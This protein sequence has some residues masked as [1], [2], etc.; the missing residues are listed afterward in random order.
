[1]TIFIILLNYAYG[2]TAASTKFKAFYNILDPA[3]VEPSISST[4]ASEDDATG[5]LPLLLITKGKRAMV[6][7]KNKL[8]V[9]SHPIIASVLLVS[10][11]R[12][13]S[14]LVK[15]SLVLSLARNNLQQQI[16]LVV[17]YLFSFFMSNCL[18]SSLK[19]QNF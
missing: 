5:T 6:Y 10:K 8:T 4:K 13:V 11:F 14:S 18:N 1:M 9:N 17:G 7:I 19:Q 15:N 2:S 16:S 3:S 12:I